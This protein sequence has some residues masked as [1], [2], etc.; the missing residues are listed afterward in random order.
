VVDLG[1]DLQKL[2]LRMRSLSWWFLFLRVTM[3]AFYHWYDIRSFLMPSKIR[4]FISE[5]ASIAYWGT[6][7]SFLV[8]EIRIRQC[9]A[10]SLFN[11]IL[12]SNF[13]KMWNCLR[14][15]T[16]ISLFIYS[17]NKLLS[18]TKPF[19]RHTQIL[20]MDWHRFR[21]HCLSKYIHQ[22]NI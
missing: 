2:V 17:L 7:V 4:I 20:C 15:N 6:Y 19:Q 1:F 5:L 21:S 10:F 16:W 12:Y 18:S 22:Y 13:C 14:Q 8:I 3:K 9:L 11:L